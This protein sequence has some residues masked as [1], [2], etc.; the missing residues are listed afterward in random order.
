MFN[1]ADYAFE[2]TS[3]LIALAALIYAIR[4]NRNSE[5]AI[6]VAKQSAVSELRLRAKES[7]AE[8]EKALLVLQTSCQS[9]REQW[10]NH[11]RKHYPPLGSRMF[12]K[13]SE[14]QSISVL[15]RSGATLLRQLRETAP[16]EDTQDTLALER[17]IGSAHAQAMQIARLQ[18]QID[19]PRPIT[20]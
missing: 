7:L 12:E 16:A 20:R 3:T 1:V 8:A 14:L 13:P 2:T 15:E 11:Y 5:V 10:E 17:F 9:S 18:L 4:A 19:S 6:E